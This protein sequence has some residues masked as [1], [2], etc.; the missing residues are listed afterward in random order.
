M[1]K[2]EIFT[3]GSARNSDGTNGGYGVVFINGSVTQYCGGSYYSTNSARMEIFGLLAGLEK[4]KPGDSVTV[5]MDC[6]WIVNTV[7]KGWV[8]RWSLENWR[9]RK[10]VDLWKKFLI[11]YQRLERKVKLQWIRGH[12]AIEDAN[13][14][15]HVADLLAAKGAS[16]ETKIKDL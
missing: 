9:G 10:N 2:I 15:N 4:C 5:W 14:Y 12:A 13:Y 11:E 1:R 16:R 7:E 8:F 6:E 3:D